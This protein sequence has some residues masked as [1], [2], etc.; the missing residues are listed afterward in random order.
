M[1]PQYAILIGAGLATCGWLYGAR[2]ARTLSRKQ[3]T[4]NVLMQASFNVEFR[5]AQKILAGAIENGKC[6]DLTDGSNEALKDAF[7]MVANHYE[8]IAAGLR[9]GDLDERMIVDSHRGQILRV[10]QFS[11]EFIWKIRDSR[12]RQAI[13]EHLEWLNKRWETHRPGKMQQLAERCF[14]RPLS[15]SRVKLHD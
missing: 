15:G 13:Y 1:E 6:P 2:R 5:G 9:N 7:R 10:Y 8:F 12:K 14:G 11:E 3:H 4:I